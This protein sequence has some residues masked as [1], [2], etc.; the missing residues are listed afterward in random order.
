LL[1]LGDAA[2]R[3]ISRSLVLESYSRPYSILDA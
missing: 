3:E 1:L 2:I